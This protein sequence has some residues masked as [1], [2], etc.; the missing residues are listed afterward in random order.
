MGRRRGFRDRGL[1]TAAALQVRSCRLT[2]RRRKGRTA[3]PQWP[4]GKRVDAAPSGTSREQRCQQ[5]LAAV[6]VAG[7]EARKLAG[8]VAGRIAQPGR[9][10][11]SGRRSSPQ[12]D[13][14]LEP[15]QF[16]Q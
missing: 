14:Q 13:L 11:S 6:F 16:H 3:S 15:M 4:G 5:Q 8:L 12:L 1:T 10:V 9:E 2:C 7:P